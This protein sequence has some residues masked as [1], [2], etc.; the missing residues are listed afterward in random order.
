[1][2]GVIPGYLTKGGGKDTASPFAQVMAGFLPPAGK[3]PPSPPPFGQHIMV[4]GT[5]GQYAS[6]DGVPY[7]NFFGAAPPPP[8]LAMH[9]HFNTGRGGPSSGTHGHYRT[10]NGIPY[11]DA[12]QA[13]F[14]VSPFYNSGYRKGQSKGGPD[15]GAL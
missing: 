8:P 10:F 3:G 9:P 14:K 1:M 12:S 13:A 15:P 4:Q 7:A 11:S 2:S 6:Y 5:K